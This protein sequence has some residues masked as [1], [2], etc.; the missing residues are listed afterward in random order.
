MDW[1]EWH[2][3]YDVPGSPL[4]ARLEIVQ[5]C[6]RSALDSEPA[7]PVR[8]VSL[9][10]GQGRDVVG[11]LADHPRRRDVTGRLVEL[12]RRNADECAKAVVAS[13]LDLEVVTG[14]A[15]TSDAYVGAVPANIVVACGI[16][17]NI[18]DAD[19]ERFVGLVPMLCAPGATVIWTRH[20]RPPD[21]TAAVRRW[22]EEAG[23]VE[24]SFAAPAEHAF[25]AVG[26]A[27]WAGEAGVLEPG[28]S[29][30][31]FVGDPLPPV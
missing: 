9:C 20:R 23:F 6:I 19:I 4:A 18:S 10:A 27:R 25:V 28:V 17:G 21:L 24:V 11:A 15:S 30:F 26:A 31:T 7:G 29:L 5:G 16:F 14:D 2:A 8:L 3:P 22:L 13:G 1:F 12:D